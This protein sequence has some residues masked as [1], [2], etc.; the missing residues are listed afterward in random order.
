MG[1]VETMIGVLLLV[2]EELLRIGRKVV[3]MFS[4]IKKRR[5]EN[6]KARDHFDDFKAVTLSFE[7]IFDSSKNPLVGFLEDI[8]VED[9]HVSRVQSSSKSYID[10]SFGCYKKRLEKFDGTKEDFELLVAEFQNIFYAYED[11]FIAPIEE[12]ERKDM[13]AKNDKL[14]KKFNMFVGDYE[15]LRRRYMEYGEKMN[16]LFDDA[17]IIRIDFNQVVPL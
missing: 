6:R 2:K 1:P 17:K 12:K 14:K 3:T 5:R 13:I 4:D 11:M 15:H 8:D 9:S 7:K 10:R 16:R